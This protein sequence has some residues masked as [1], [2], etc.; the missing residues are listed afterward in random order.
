MSQCAAR[1]Q[2]VIELQPTAA[3]FRA[4]VLWAVFGC[5]AALADGYL[6]QGVFLVEDGDKLVAANTKLN[7]MD[8]IRL[9]AKEKIEQ[10]MVA[11]Q[12]AVVI[13]NDRLLGY[14]GLGNGWIPKWRSVKEDIERIE[15][16][17]NGAVVVT[18]DRLLVFNAGNGLWVQKLR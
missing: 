2:R 17:G 18:S 15:A 8:S 9:I 7:R 11:E 16:S 12:V 14:S 4:L 3:L 10:Q 6:P 13:T 1:K 5:G